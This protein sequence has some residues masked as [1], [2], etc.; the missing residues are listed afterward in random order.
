[1]EELAFL[2]QEKENQEPAEEERP[3]EEMTAA[4]SQDPKPGLLKTPESEQGP[5]TGIQPRISPPCSPQS[6][7]S[8]PLDD[9]RGASSPPPPQEP[10]STLSSRDVAAPWQS[11]KTTRVI[12]EAETPHSDHLEQSH[13]KGESTP[14]QTCQSEGNAFQQPQ[15]TDDH[16]YG[17]KDVSCSNSIRKELRFDIFQ[18]SDSNSNYYL[19]EAEPE[20]SEMAPSMLEIAIRNAKAYLLK[21][22]GKSGLNL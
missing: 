2:K 9:L 12:T 13:D 7:G 14:H 20:A 16:L 18:E 4:S 17:P 22:S 5:E 11:D 15:Q 21:T 8:T 3:W 10:S 19:N 6:R 1:M